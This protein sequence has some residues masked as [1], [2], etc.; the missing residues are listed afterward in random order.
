MSGIY[1]HIPFCKQACFYCN[2]HFSTSLRLKNEMTDAICNEIALRKDY[3][4]DKY[5]TSIYFG[6]GSPSLLDEYDLEKIFI[7]M[8]RHFNWDNQTEITI[9]ANPD[10]INTEKLHIFK[11]WGINRL[12]IGVQSFFAIDLKWMNR[13]HDADEASKCLKLSQ[14][15]GFENI[16]ID[17]IYGSPTT[18]AQMWDEN[19][20]KTLDLGIPHIS[21][22]CLTVEEK[23]ALYHQVKANKTAS[24]DPEQAAE[25]FNTLMET[26]F[27]FGYD[28]YEI[29]NFGLPGHHA[30]HNTNYWKGVHYLG[31]GPSAHSF[32]GISRTWNIANNKKYIDNII[33]EV[34]PQETEILS[35]S[36]MYNEYIMTG[37]RTMWGVNDQKIQKF[38]SDYFT[39][40]ISMIQDD[41]TQGHVLQKNG[42]YTL[43]KEGKHFADRI[44]MNLFYVD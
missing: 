21:S 19:L 3:L 18:T 20:Q 7:S 13:A 1:I 14:D 31:I 17:L 9:E 15:A 36:S 32:N 28:H 39:Y 11:K 41:I 27:A 2:F 34:L 16:T 35:V 33:I 37:L 29:S 4:N 12:S 23:T 10:D 26:L 40:F 22:Y 6:G 38:G 43:S 8:S 30:I 24:P 42:D 25:Q 5:L 44:A